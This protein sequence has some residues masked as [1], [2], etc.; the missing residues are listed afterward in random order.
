MGIAWVGRD[1]AS[2]WGACCD[3]RGR[4]WDGATGVREVLAE[5]LKQAGYATGGFGKWGHGVMDSEGAAEGKGFDTF[6]GYYHQVHAH[7]YYS[8]F[9][10]EDGTPFLLRGNAGIY[11][12]EAQEISSD[13]ESL[14]LYKQLSPTGPFVPRKTPDGDYRVYDTM[15]ILR[16]FRPDEPRNPR[17]HR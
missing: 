12:L 16:G 11:G 14:Q 15:L 6:F 3:A 5:V 8:P 9:L 13:L 7:T 1:A 10:V 2:G 4:D 17:S